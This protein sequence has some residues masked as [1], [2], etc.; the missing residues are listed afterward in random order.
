MMTMSGSGSSCKEDIHGSDFCL[1][2][3]NLVCHILDGPESQGSTR[4]VKGFSTL[5][6]EGG[7]SRIGWKVR[8]KDASEFRCL[9]VK[10]M[11][12]VL[13]DSIKDIREG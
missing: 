12:E 6:G 2:I 1:E 5:P 8:R 7:K 10:D 9:T 13:D 3:E 4:M 11:F